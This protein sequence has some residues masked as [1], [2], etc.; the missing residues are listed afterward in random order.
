MMENTTM[1]EFRYKMIMI[2]YLTSLLRGLII[3]DSYRL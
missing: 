2:Y 3:Y 1:D